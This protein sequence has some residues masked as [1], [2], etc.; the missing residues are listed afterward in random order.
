MAIRK[1]LSLVAAVLLL[2]LLAPG[3]CLA[4]SRQSKGES[5]EQSYVLSQRAGRWPLHCLPGGRAAICPC[6]AVASRP[7]ILFAD[8]RAAVAAPV[9]PLSHGRLRLSRLQ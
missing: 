1:Q 6:P 5:Y 2:I 4:Q 9:R 8:V 7:A 3:W